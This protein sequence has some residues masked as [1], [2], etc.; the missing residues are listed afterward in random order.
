MKVYFD[1]NIFDYI[2]RLKEASGSTAA[3]DN[4]YQAVCDGKL[5]ILLST[6]VLEETL[7]LLKHSKSRLKQELEVIFNLVEKRRMIKPADD[8][9]REA[10]QSYAFERRLPDMF[11]KTPRILSDFL[12]KGKVARELEQF[13]EGT[14]S[15]KNDFLESITKAFE[16]L[17]RLGEERNV[18]RPDD[19]QEFWNGMA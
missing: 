19:F 13:I 17:R 3:I 12:T 9:L 4:L 5:T 8:L 11:T 1:R 15:R 16:E 18:S 6:T 14:I 7:P 2:K 10:V